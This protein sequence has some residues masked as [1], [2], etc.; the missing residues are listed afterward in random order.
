MAVVPCPSCGREFLQRRRGRQRERFCS[1]RCGQDWKKSGRPPI[2]R[3]EPQ[4][5]TGRPRRERPAPVVKPALSQPVVI[6]EPDGF[7][8]PELVAME[9]E[10][11]ESQRAD[12]EDRPHE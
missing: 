3:Y 9:M 12:P 2:P 6:A 8:W 10:R 11:L 7:T 4:P 1:P 5:S